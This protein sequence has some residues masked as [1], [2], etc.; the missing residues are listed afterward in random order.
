MKDV[1]REFRAIENLSVQNSP[2]LVEVFRCGRLQTTDHSFIDMELCSLDL[3]QFLR[4][5]VDTT[6][7]QTEGPQTLWQIASGLE[8]IHS[9][10]AVH[11][12]LKPNNGSSL[13]YQNVDHSTTFKR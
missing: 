13:K 1:E 8:F 5:I 12:D 2:F 7:L 9:C 6:E 3:S 10:N 4:R 11:R